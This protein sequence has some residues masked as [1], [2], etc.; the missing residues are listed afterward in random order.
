MG[1]HPERT[2]MFKVLAILFGIF[3]ITTGLP[4]LVGLMM[5][6]EGNL[7]L[8][9]ILKGVLVLV[10][11]RLGLGLFRLTLKVTGISRTWRAMNRRRFHK[12]LARQERAAA[13]GGYPEVQP[14]GGGF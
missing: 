4:T 7:A 12:A 13:Y 1:L 8:T 14:S 10:A 2:I 11:I 5:M 3:L 9:Y 6:G